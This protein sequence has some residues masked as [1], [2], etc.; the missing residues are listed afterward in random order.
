MKLRKLAQNTKAY[1]A[2]IMIIL[3]F[4]MMLFILDIAISG[5]ESLLMEYEDWG[6]PSFPEGDDPDW[7]DGIPIVDGIFSFFEGV[8]D[9][10][11]II[12][13]WVG[14][15]L[16]LFANIIALNIPVLNMVPYALAI[17]IP[18]WGAMLYAVIK[19]LPTT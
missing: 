19:A 7:W 16:W 10:T 9:T 8:A 15:A 6:M 13:A 1:M 18:I 2:P 4:I 3:I 17:K 5:K 12:F 14:G 11:V